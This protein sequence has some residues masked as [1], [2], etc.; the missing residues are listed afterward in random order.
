MENLNTAM[1]SRLPLPKPPLP[2]QRAIADCLHRET[3]RMDALVAKVRESIE[4]WREY[5][6][7]L[8]GV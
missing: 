2:E 1:L 3:A 5:R 8:G 4:R 7:A 6:A